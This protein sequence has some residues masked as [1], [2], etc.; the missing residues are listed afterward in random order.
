MNHPHDGDNPD[1]LREH[2]AD[3]TVEAGCST[4]GLS[5]RR[6]YQKEDPHP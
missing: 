1:I 5:P 6:L 3:D 4:R 2:T